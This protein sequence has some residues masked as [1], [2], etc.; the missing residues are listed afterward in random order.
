MMMTGGDCR[1]PAVATTNQRERSWLTCSTLIYL[2][3]IRLEIYSVDRCSF[4]FKKNGQTFIFNFKIWRNL[5]LKV[6]LLKLISNLL[7]SI[8]DNTNLLSC[9]FHKK[10]TMTS[11]CMTRWLASNELGKTSSLTHFR[12]TIPS[13]T[14]TKPFHFHEIYLFSIVTWSH[15]RENPRKT[16]SRI[17]LK[18]N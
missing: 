6:E 17:T 16:T 14:N 12:H 11:V 4:L 9:N 3:S 7:T 10:C 13:L 8:S 18:L 1:V 15:F 5:C 2:Y